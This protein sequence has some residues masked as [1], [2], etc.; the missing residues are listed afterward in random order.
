[1]A[2]TYSP[3]LMANR[4]PT[5]FLSLPRELRQQALLD[6]IDPP[7][8]DLFPESSH[9]ED[10]RND[11][12]FERH[13]V[14]IQEIKTLS[15]YLKQATSNPDIIAD[16]NYMETQLEKK[17]E[18]LD[19]AWLQKTLDDGAERWKDA[20]DWAECEAPDEQMNTINTGTQSGSREFAGFERPCRS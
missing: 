2:P 7:P 11:D 18:D 1:M 20:E 3:G 8:R 4:S 14:L 12:W 17:L 16:I 10:G 5:D 15:A 6:L 13:D 9:Y 19:G